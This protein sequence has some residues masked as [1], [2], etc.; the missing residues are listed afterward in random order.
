VLLSLCRGQ[1]GVEA[2][3][4]R[5]YKARERM[6]ES[7]T[8]L[9]CV[10]LCVCFGGGYCV[11]HTHM[12]SKST[13]TLFTL[14]CSQISLAAFTP[15]FQASWQLALAAS[16]AGLKIVA[17]EPFVGLEALYR[18]SGHRDRG[19][20]T[21]TSTST[22]SSGGG[23]GEGESAGEYL[24]HTKDPRIYTLVPAR[25]TGSSSSSSSSSNNNIPPPVAGP[26]YAHELHLWC[27]ASLLQLAPSALEERLRAAVRQCLVG[28]EGGAA[29]RGKAAD[30]LAGLRFVERCVVFFFSVLGQLLLSAKIAWIA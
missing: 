6:G 24:Y 2:R 27:H 25:P 12:G 19:G 16:G 3:D 21:S 30:C 14:H 7:G 10:Y 13:T 29:L 20:G 8:H 4:S 23:D 15:L 11:L 18:P 1:S 9:C 28:M 22:S 5:A 26:V 17:A